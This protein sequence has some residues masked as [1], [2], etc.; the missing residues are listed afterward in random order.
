[1]KNLQLLY[2]KQ[3]QIPIDDVQKIRLSSDDD[4]LTFLATPNAISQINL[5]NDEINI[6]Y[7][8]NDSK[9][10]DFEHLPIANE[11]SIA[12]EDGDVI[13][14]NI[15]TLQA[16]SVTF[17]D[18]GIVAMAWSPTQEVVA[19]VTQTKFLV[20]MDTSY[21]P[22]N[23]HN[24][25][26]PEFGTCEFVSVGWGKKETQFHGTA[27]KQAAKQQTDN[28]LVQSEDQL[29]K[30]ISIVWR[31][32]GELFAVSFV[33]DGFRLFQVYDKEGKLLYTSEKRNGLEAAI[34]WRP[35]GTWIGVPQIL[36]NKYLISL[37]EKNGLKHR[38][39]VLPFNASEVRFK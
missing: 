37:F 11:L 27:G 9:I 6:I 24:L 29:D 3:K 32:D 19:F 20:V 35:M 5:Q 1:M 15:E 26:D 21:E 34:D 12:T 13:R 4:N 33:R 7:E 17:C 25:D 18:G 10:V 30:T 16:E 8:T 38:E 31:G 23:E 36:P 28:G 39:I 22:I 14:L 2:H